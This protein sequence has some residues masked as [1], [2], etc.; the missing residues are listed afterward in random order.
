MEVYVYDPY[1]YPEEVKEEYG[2]E[3]VKDV[4]KYKPYDAIVVAVKHKEFIK[5]FSFK[6]FKELMRH[7]IPVLIDIKGMYDREKALLVRR[8]SVLGL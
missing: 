3:L 5:K 6:K 7:A 4:N 8:I 2:I 1:A